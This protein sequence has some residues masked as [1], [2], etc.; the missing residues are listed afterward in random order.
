MATRKTPARKPA[1]KKAASRRPPARRPAARKKAVAKRPAGRPAAR[2]PKEARRAAPRQ[3]AVA[4]VRDKAAAA[5]GA[6]ARLAGI[7]TEA[8]LKATGRAWD[9]WLRVLDGAGAVA[10]PHRAI[11]AM[12]AKKFGV[13]AWW[14]QM[15][16]VGYEQAR[17]LRAVHQKPGG[18]TA[19]ASK[20][21]S[22]SLERVFAAWNDP[23]LRA[24]WLGNA[25][26]EVRRAHD[27]KSMR[28]AWTAGGSSV[29]V[30]FY[31]KGGGKSQVAV[32]HDRLADEKAVVK[33][34]TF[35]AGA[36]GRLKSMLEK[37][38]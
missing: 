26:V 3:G 19:T 9:E 23:G 2:K 28:I 1:A 29:E 36:L 12:L 33:Q 31:A 4:F 6:P 13:P 22:S 14:S 15:V 8:V 20:T 38:A 25:P 35:W 16:T 11:A 37:A 5:V 32:Q 18:F 21:L 17:G 30:N 34:K 10:M 27:R 24:L 7:G